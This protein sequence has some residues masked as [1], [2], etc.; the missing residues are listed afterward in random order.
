MLGSSMEPTQK[1]Y[2]VV[3]A[4]P[5]DAD[6][7]ISGSVARLTREGNTVH[8]LVLTSGDAGTED[9]SISR[10][11][12]AALREAEQDAAGR[13]LGLSSTAYLRL[14]DGEL[15]P[16]LAVRKEVVRHIRRVRADVVLCQD[17][18]MLVSDDSVYVNHPDHRAAGQVA[19]D[20]AFPGAGNP[21]AYRD[22]TAAG[23]PSYKVTEIWLYMTNADRV[24]YWMDISQT[25]DQKM[26]AL[27]EHESQ[28]GPSVRTGEFRAMMEDWSRQ[29]AERGKIEGTFAEGFQRIVL[30][31]EK[32]PTE[33]EAVEVRT[34]G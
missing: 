24:N 9:T 23:F 6:F 32:R 5:D 20:A 28:I 8:Y 27:V 10:E 3:A 13:V 12:L 34:E 7:A 22:L 17:P 26:Q 16:S 2:L 11:E 29:S 33:A 19:I 14:P 4:H 18:R 1:T 25:F 30:E 15:E 31:Q 21:G